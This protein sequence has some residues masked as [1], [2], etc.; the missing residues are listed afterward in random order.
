MDQIIQQ[1][2]RAFLQAE[3]E[4]DGLDKCLTAI[5]PT[6]DAVW[7]Q[8]MKDLLNLSFPLK[9]RLFRALEKDIP[10]LPTGFCVF[11]VQSKRY[12]T[13]RI[14]QFEVDKIK[15]YLVDYF[16]TVYGT[17]LALNWIIEYI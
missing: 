16:E 2:L 17:D 7:F 10:S 1:S 12:L 8:V 3:D 9:K 11:D 13:L 5:C 4:Q 6:N 15:M 14:D